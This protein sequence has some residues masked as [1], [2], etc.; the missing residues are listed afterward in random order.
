[1]DLAWKE[2]V[3]QVAGLGEAGGGRWSS[4]L[5]AEAAAGRGEESMLKE[6]FWSSWPGSK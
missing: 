6:R 2:T 5:G 3:S 4:R 1:M